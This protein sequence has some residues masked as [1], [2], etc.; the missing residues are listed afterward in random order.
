MKVRV[1]VTAEDL[2]EGIPRSREA[3][4]V[5]QALKRAVP[6]WLVR[7]DITSVY[8]STW[9]SYQKI[10]LPEVAVWAIK[11]LLVEKHRASVRPFSFD[12]ELPARLTRG[13]G[14][15]E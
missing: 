9:H 3:C 8:F 15:D 4:P 5:A 12:L 1:D 11:D 10:K 14:S 6:G 7:V 2:R 13:E